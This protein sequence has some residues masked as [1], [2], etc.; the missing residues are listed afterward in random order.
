M[1][2]GRET[3]GRLE[4]LPIRDLFKKEAQQFTPWLESHID[5]LAERLGLELEV[6]QREQN[7]GGFKVDLLCEDKNKRPVIIENQLEKTNHDHLGKLLTYL[8]NLDA[9]AAIWVTPEPRIEHKKVIDWLNEYTSEDIS[10]YLIKIEASKIGDSPI[11]PLFT[12]LAG[13]DEQ[14]KK[15]GEGKKEWAERHYKRKEF[16]EG[17]LKKSK[18]M[19]NL[20]RNNSPSHS[21]YIYTGAGIAG[22]GFNYIIRNDSV[23]I[24]LYIDT[25]K[26]TGK[27]NKAIFDALFK[28]KH[29][30]EVAFGA[31]LDWQRHNEERASRIEK[32][33][34]GGGLNTPDKWPELQDTLIDAMIR[35]HK[36]IHPRLKKI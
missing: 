5:V 21:S 24:D 27:Q 14:I 12:I 25:D 30:I 23:S 4:I 36:A 35:F 1:S 7:V 16:W 9:S 15:I 26:K 22:I 29:A 11:A 31:E 20:F 17:L 6:V 34:P 18:K 13:P 19:T 33:Y 3:V 28:Q 2:N 8:V 10:F 32:R